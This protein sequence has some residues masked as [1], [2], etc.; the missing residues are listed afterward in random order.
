M[1]WQDESGQTY[2]QTRAQ[3][4]VWVTRCFFLVL[5]DLLC[6]F[7]YVTLWLNNLC[8]YFF[9]PSLF[10]RSF[11]LSLYVLPYFLIIFVHLFSRADFHPPLF[12]PFLRVRQFIEMV[13]GTDSEVRCLGGRSPKSQDSYPGSPRPFS[14]PSHKA[15]SSQP[16]L[17][18]TVRLCST[19][20]L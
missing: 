17:T 14:S 19:C 2:R 1:R 5:A 7:T 13:N 6:S 10:L 8:N 9:S 3:I 20:S 15:S 16:Y 4:I 12:P 18:G 11:L